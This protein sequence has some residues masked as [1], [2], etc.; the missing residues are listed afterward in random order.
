ME[1][2]IYTT[3]TRIWHWGS[4]AIAVGIAAYIAYVYLTLP[5]VRSL[6]T[7]NPAS[8]AFIDLHAAKAQQMGMAP[9][10]LQR[11]IPYDQISPH[12]KHAVLVAEDAT[13]F[14][15]GGID[16]N[17]LQKS[18]A[19][20]WKKIELTGSGTITQQLARNLYLSP[21]NNLF[22]KFREV[23][24]ARRLEAELSKHRIF[25]IYLNVIEWGNGIWGAEA[26][27]QLYFKIPAAA[28][29]REQSALMAAALI[30]PRSL[31]S[32]KPPKRLLRRQ[33]FILR[34]MDESAPPPSASL[35]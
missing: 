12:L 24:I 27:A 33:E 9:R 16:F 21:S 5:D 22:S 25:E 20:D 14:S 4:R 29:N 3:Y 15:H 11:W 13:F 28:L 1:K 6:Q 34:R 23:L 32:G 19:I 8:T 7:M 2:G 31:N 10:R 30:N 26:A 18:I 35:Q 17:R